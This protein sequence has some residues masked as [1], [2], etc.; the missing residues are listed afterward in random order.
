M[1]SPYGNPQGAG[2]YNAGSAAQFSVTTPSGFPVQQ[3]FV[4]W[5]GDYT[6][7]S[8][9]GSITMDKP[10]VVQAV[11]ST[12]YLP[13]IGIVVVAAAIV[14]GLLFWR[15]RRGGG[16]TPETKPT[17]STPGETSTQQETGTQQANRPKV[18][19]VWK[20]ERADQKFCT[21]CGETLTPA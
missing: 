14:G 1:N 13:L 19:E 17:P 7:N 11:W 8:P 2:Y 10:H 20:R 5:Q 9:Q 18:C 3:I 15:S 12:S 21:N 16:G 6:G 4:K